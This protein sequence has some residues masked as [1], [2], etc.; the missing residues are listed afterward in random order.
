MTLEA[1]EDSVI[2]LSTDRGIQAGKNLAQATPGEE[3]VITGENSEV[4]YCVA[5]F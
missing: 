1:Q 5:Q 4:V 2:D 3:V